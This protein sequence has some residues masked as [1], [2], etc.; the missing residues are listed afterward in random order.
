[1]RH[2]FTLAAIAA[3]LLL[4]G[5]CATERQTETAIGTGTGAAAGAVLGGAVGGSRGA[6][7]G[8]AVGA[9]VGAAVGYNWPLVK[10]K[11]GIA[12][13]D[14]PLNLTE[15]TDGSMKVVVPGSVSF[16]SGSAS[17]SSQVRP[18]LDKIAG[19]LTEHPDTRVNVIGH[20]DSSGNAAANRELALRRA[21]A[22]ANYLAERGVS[23]DRILVE[24]RGDVEPL[25]ENRT[26]AGRTQNRRVE[27]VIRD[28]GS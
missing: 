15:Q 10:E 23:R 25:A 26:E 19:T 5:G 3:A 24:S 8:A 2:E 17:L 1:M 28:I 4:G 16:T 12:T 14:T 7:V 6:V 11:L 27:L 13:K 9:G 18:S 22:V 21:Q 20:S